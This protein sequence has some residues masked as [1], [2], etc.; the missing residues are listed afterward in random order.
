MKYKM[1]RWLTILAHKFN[2]H[3]APKEHMAQDGRTFAWCQWCGLRG[4]IVT[5]MDLSL[6]RERLNERLP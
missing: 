2:W 1:I 5:S 3:Y 4:Q 6:A